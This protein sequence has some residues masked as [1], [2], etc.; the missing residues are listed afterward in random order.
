MPPSSADF[1]ALTV[2]KLDR[3]GVISNN[4][5]VWVVEI[6]DRYRPDAEE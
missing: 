5:D 4:G 1:E 6:D 3:I 2:E